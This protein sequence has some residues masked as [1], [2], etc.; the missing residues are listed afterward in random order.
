MS[1]TLDEEH[2]EVL[3][4]VLGEEFSVLIDTFLAD[5]PKRIVE[6]RD[7][8]AENNIAG[9]EV[10]AHTLKGSSGNIGANALSASCATLVQQVRQ[11]II[12]DPKQRIDDIEH[13][14]EDVRPLL[15][16]KRQ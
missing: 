6:M 8:L 1:E 10:P 13:A 11:Q 7:A 9:L 12:D 5:A 16:A 4:D 2:I 15:E 3:R 14:L